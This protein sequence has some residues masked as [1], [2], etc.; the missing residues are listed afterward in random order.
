MMNVH[1]ITLFLGAAL[2][3][4]SVSASEYISEISPRTAVNLDSEQ[5]RQELSEILYSQ[6][7][8]G[9]TEPVVLEYSAQYDVSNLQIH[10][11]VVGQV[12]R[13]LGQIPIVGGLF[14]RIFGEFDPPKTLKLRALLFPALDPRGYLLGVHGLQSNAR[15]Y[16]SSGQ[17]LA[18]RGVTS[19]FYDRRGSGISDSVLDGNGR[20]MRGH[21]ASTSLDHLIGLP[22]NQAV[23]DPSEFLEDI[24]VTYE[25][26]YLVRSLQQSNAPIHLYANCFG[27]RI[28]LA[29]AGEWRRPE[30]GIAS[31][32]MTSP[33]TNMKKG[34]PNIGGR[35]GAV[36]PIEA[37]QRIPLEDVDFTSN[38]EAL[39]E[40]GDD[41]HSLTLRKV[42]NR[43][44]L[45]A[46]GL[47]KKMKSVFKNQ[48]LAQVPALV[49]IPSK[50]KIIK[51]EETQQTFAEN[52]PGPT[53]VTLLDTEHLIEFDDQA[54]ADFVEIVSQWIYNQNSGWAGYKGAANFASHLKVQA[55]EGKLP[56]L[57][58][59]KTKAYRP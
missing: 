27:A 12:G 44:L 19:L 2:L 15:W 38:P 49:F 17:A 10:L 4:L 28:A 33:G 16:A 54:R 41:S 24:Q 1:N 40:M 7:L 50:D 22:F 57:L 56:S 34:E 46:A 53:L 43:F 55:E 5:G 30:E 9:I 31:I 6:K 37:Y 39:A 42:T 26:L 58:S 18:E 59:E 32:I 45:S 29:Y 14:H 52:Y 48:K 20:P 13:V 35:L 36:A 21:V 3:P 11:P 25:H 8:R 47:T 51:T 23:G